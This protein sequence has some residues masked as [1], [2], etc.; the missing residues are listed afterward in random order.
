MLVFFFIDGLLS[1]TS[2]NIR[3]ST[4]QSYV[5]EEYRGRYNGVFQMACNTGII[6]GELIAGA[7]AEYFSCRAIIIG[8][9]A[10]ILISTYTVMYKGREFVKPIY[11]R[12]V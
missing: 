11:N 9:M 10:L 3:L 2:Y 5:P 8:L 12:D 4:T 7:L 1:V 6:L